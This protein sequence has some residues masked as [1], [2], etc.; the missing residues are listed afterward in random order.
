MC[1][2]MMMGGINEKNRSK[3]IPL[4]KKMGD[5]MTPGNTDGLGYA[6]VDAAGNLFGERWLI[7]K[8]A[9]KFRPDKSNFAAASERAS[10][11][12]NKVTGKKDVKMVVDTA[13]YNSFGASPSLEKAVAITL[14]TRMAT[15]GRGMQNTH[16]FVTGDTSVIHNGVIS[17]TSDFTFKVSTCDS[18]AIL[19][20][21]LE[22]KVGAN[23]EKISEVANA[24][25]GYYA[26]GTF[27]RDAAG[28][29]IMDIYSGN[30][31]DLW[32]TYITELDTWMFTSRKEHLESA[33][34]GFGFT[35][36][37][38]INIVEG[39]MMRFNPV[40]GEHLSNTKFTVPARWGYSPSQSSG[41]GTNANYNGAT[42]Y[43]GHGAAN[44]NRSESNV[45]NIRSNSLPVT[46]EF[47]D[48]L[49]TVPSLAEC[50]QQ[51]LLEFERTIR[52]N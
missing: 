4:I 41:T 38:P 8:Q 22:H 47:E 35:Y 10:V 16:P 2:V 23:P 52:G 50:S 49:S 14:H 6:A 9:F 45:R 26:V 36:S 5:L 39:E 3:V 44:S 51:E 28:N 24:L 37:E 18:E 32:F 13:N 42:I 46:K 12:I 21:Y 29:R 1:K 19:I 25:K 40:T 33:L 48:Y 30:N 15:S 20:A 17:N 31:T 7:N 27:A 43:Q 34:D 11:I